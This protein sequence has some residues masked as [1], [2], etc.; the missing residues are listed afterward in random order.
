MLTCLFTIRMNWIIFQPQGD[1]DLLLDFESGACGCGLRT[2]IYIGTQ[3]TVLCER[4]EFLTSNDR[5]DGFWIL[6]TFI[7]TE[8]ETSH[9]ST[10]RSGVDVRVVDVMSSVRVR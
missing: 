7:D 9:T 2:D 3:R 1:R 10:H 4:S 8:K 5:I 6:V